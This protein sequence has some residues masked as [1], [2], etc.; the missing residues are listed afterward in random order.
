MLGYVFQ[1]KNCGEFSKQISQGE[2]ILK[3]GSFYSL[4]MNYT[5]LA[6]TV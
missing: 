6:E 2:V 4:V 5:L 1:T 3:L